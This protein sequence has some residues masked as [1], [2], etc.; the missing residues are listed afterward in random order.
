MGVILLSLERKL[1]WL[2]NS[3]EARGVGNVSR[4]NLSVEP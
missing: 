1:Y 4:L 3:G 2:S